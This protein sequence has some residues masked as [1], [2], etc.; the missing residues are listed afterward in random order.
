MDRTTINKSPKVRNPLESNRKKPR[1]TADIFLLFLR[2]SY[3]LCR[4][5]CRSVVPLAVLFFCAVAVPAPLPFCLCFSS[6]GSN[7]FFNLFFLLGSSS[8]FKSMPNGR[9]VI[10]PFVPCD[11]RHF[12]KHQYMTFS[13][14]GFI[15]FVPLWLDGAAECGKKKSPA[16]VRFVSTPPAGETN[17]PNKRERPKNRTFNRVFHRHRRR[18]LL[19]FLLFF[20]LRFQRVSLVA[21]RYRVFFASLLYFNWENGIR[22]GFFLPEKSFF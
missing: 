14:F 15:D 6:I 4:T 20:F 16:P 9:F 5:C 8:P 17:D 11:G 19:L 12:W 2:R 1:S 21:R 13:P 10:G 18:L 22:L 3:F 7:L